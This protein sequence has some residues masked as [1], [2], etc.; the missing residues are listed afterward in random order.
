MCAAGRATNNAT[1]IELARE[2]DLGMA[3]VKLGKARF[4]L[5]YSDPVQLDLEACQER[6]LGSESGP[7]TP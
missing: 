5:A 7:L 2:A 3:P 4:E 6:A 1:S